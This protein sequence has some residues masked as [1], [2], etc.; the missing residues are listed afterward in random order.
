MSH[1]LD[2]A[3]AHPKNGVVMGGFETGELYIR[4]YGNFD[5]SVLRLY[6]DDAYRIVERDTG[7]RPAAHFTYDGGVI[8]VRVA[9]DTQ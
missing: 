7:K 4:A 1:Q 5:G 9:E 3:G 6:L 2:T 8:E